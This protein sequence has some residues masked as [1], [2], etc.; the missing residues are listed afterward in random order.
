MRDPETVKYY[1]W[2]ANSHKKIGAV[3][4]PEVPDLTGA[5]GRK[6]D[7]RTTSAQEANGRCNI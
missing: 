3:A 5:R 4:R 1:S 7:S 2:E 6:P